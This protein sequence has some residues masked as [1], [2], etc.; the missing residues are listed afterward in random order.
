MKKKNQQLSLIE[1]VIE[2]SFARFFLFV[3]A[4]ILLIF[5]FTQI[6]LW[7]HTV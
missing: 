5:L 2:D 4:T 1:V 6:A 3:A 7:T